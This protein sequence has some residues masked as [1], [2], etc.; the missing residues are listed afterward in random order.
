MDL[1]AI[2]DNSLCQGLQYGFL[3]LGLF[4]NLRLLD[5]P[6]LTVEGSFALG[7]AVAFSCSHFFGLGAWALLVSIVL[8]AGAG[9]CTGLLYTRAH[10]GKLLSGIIVSIGLY[11]INFR[12]MG[13][14][15]NGY[16][17]KEEN[18]FTPINNLNRR[19]IENSFGTENPL[20]VYPLFNFLFII[21][22]A[23]VLFLLYRLLTSERGSVLRFTRPESKFFLESIGEDYNKNLVIGLAIGNSFASLAGALVVF[24][25]GS[26]SL[27]MG[28]GIILVALVAV[29]LGELIIQIFHKD[30]T[31][32]WP[33]LLSPFLGA[34][35]YYLLIR[36]VQEL[37][38]YWQL[39]H[40]FPDP[41]DQLQY[42]QTDVKLLAVIII[43]IVSII[44]RRQV[45]S[46]SL[47]ERL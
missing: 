38:T 43:I 21:I 37:N 2:L 40:G 30:L 33:T 29:V 44:Q 22:A 27:T 12:I 42:F 16:L 1:F 9:V 35:V 15:A 41:T 31:D 23:F 11:S 4:I 14:Q 32:I 28:F 17:L 39:H 24:H 36:V 18:P 20:Y 7:A 6:D 8:G 25:T 3:A 47:P 26:A 10:C 19:F 13:A 46:S 34:I 5:F 45:L